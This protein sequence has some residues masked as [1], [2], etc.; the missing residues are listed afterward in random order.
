MAIEAAKICNIKEKN[1]FKSLKKIKEVNGRLELVKKFPNGIKVFVDYA[2]TPDALLKVLKSLNKDWGSNISLVFGCGGD[3]DKKKRSLMGKIAKKYSKKIYVTDDNPRNESP[4]KIR[5]EIVKSIR[6]IK[7]FNISDR[8]KAI[9]KAI[10]NSEPNEVILIAGKGHEQDQIYK[11]KIYKISDKQIIKNL[12]IKIKP[13]STSKLIYSENKYLLNKITRKKNISDFDGV[14]IDSRMVRKNNIFLTIKG[15]NNDGI[16]FADQALKKGAKYIVSSKVIKK[17]KKKTIRVKDEIKFLKDYAKIKRHNTQA[18]IIAIT[19]SAG[20]TSLKNLIKHLLLNYDKTYASPKS[21]N[22]HFGVPLSLSNMNVIH[23]YGVFEVGMSKKGE[24]KNL[25]KIIR[26]HIGIITNIGEAHIENFKNISEIAKAKAE[27][28][29]SI[30]NNGTIILN[31]DDK[32]FKYL[33]KLSKLKKLKIVT[34]GKSNQADITCQKILEKNKYRK[35]FIKIKNKKMSFEINNLNIYN[36]LASLS[37]I[38]E[39]GLNL[40]KIKQSFKNFQASEGRGKVHVISRYKK[41][42]N[43]IDESYNANPLSVKNAI[44][45]FH[46]IKNEKSKKYLI[47]GDMLELGHKSKKY[48]EDLSKV[49]NNS[50][51]DKVFIKGEKTLFTYKNLNKNKQGNILQNNSDIDLVLKNIIKNNDYLMIKGSNATGLNSY[52]KKIIRGVN[53]I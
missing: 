6:P 24:I 32:Y 45:N 34:F 46:S 21:Y 35:I 5:N 18:K 39:L 25:S 48:H 3:R 51:I 1:I 43:L 52:S 9:K 8:K 33:Y 12:N 22:N 2:H 11:N 17:N 30:E 26:P 4:S 23:R 42:F 36:V 50:N 7:C 38:N 49:I 19:G 40:N 14:A 47:L 29:S 44:Y 31:R 27:I 10:L 15:K 53:V 41:K 16:K 37:A 20:K 28:I 13:I